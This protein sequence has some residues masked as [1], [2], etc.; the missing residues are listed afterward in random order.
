MRRVLVAVVAVLSS[1]TLV[2]PALASSV[3]GP[4][5]SDYQH[6]NGVSIGWGQ[7]ATAG[8]SFAFVK[9]SQGTYYTNPYYA[10]DVAQAGKAGLVHGAYA[11]ADPTESAVSQAQYFAQVIGSQNQPGDLPPVL[12]LE[13]TGG[14]TA[15]QL[16]SWV[17]SWL[18]T[19]QQLTQRQP[20][21]Y[22]SPY[23]WID[24]LNNTTQFANY[25]LW[26]ADYCSC[27]APMTFGGWGAAWTFWQFTDSATISGIS[28]QV[29]ES[30][31]R[32]PLST[33][34]QSF[35]EED[36]GLPTFGVTATPGDTT[37]QVSWNAY[38]NATG[39]TV[40]SSAGNSYPAGSAT[41]FQATGLT[42]GDSYGFSITAQLANGDS[43]S[44]GWSIP[45]IPVV[46]DQITLT[47]TPNTLLSEQSTTVAVNVVRTTDGSPVTGVPL[48][49]YC[50][51]VT[52]NGPIEV[53]S[54][55]TDSNGDFSFVHVVG[56][57]D[58]YQVQLQGNPAAYVEPASGWVPVTV[59]PTLSAAP[60]QS[61][62]V[63]GSNITVSGTVDPSRGGDALTVQ[64]YLSGEWHDVASTTGN[65]TGGY[66]VPVHLGVLGSFPFQVLLAANAVHA[67]GTS[68]QFTELV[69]QASTTPVKLSATLTPSTTLAGDR[70]TISGGLSPTSGGDQLTAEADLGGVWHSVAWATANS[71]GDYTT[72]IYAGLV[73]SFPVRMVVA[74][75]TQH[76]AGT[77]PTLTLKVDPPANAAVSAA[78]S[79]AQTAQGS[80][81]TVSGVVSPASA[82]APVDVQAAIGGQWHNVASA[83]T[84]SAG[85]YAAS[86][87][88]G[89]AGSFPIQVVAPATSAYS[90]GVSKTLT[91]QVLPPASVTLQITPAT[92]TQGNRVTVS[93]TVSRA[94]AGDPVVIQALLGNQWHNVASTTTN[95]AGDYA[96]SV[97]AG[98]AG[99]FLVRSVAT[100]TSAYSTG[101]SGNATLTVQHAALTSITMAL[102]P[103]TV[104]RGGRVAV[105]GSVSPTIA[106]EPISVLALIGNQWH[107]VA[108]ATTNSAGDYAASIYA[109]LAG[110][111]PVF[112]QGPGS[113]P[114]R[115]NQIVL[116]VN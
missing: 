13:Q 75:T 67:A 56:L 111:F 109:G 48:V 93:G 62:A 95:S 57:S 50:Q 113:S 80:R 49:I 63:V 92:T 86:I 29:D 88:A 100:A 41:T 105:S 65:S 73:G 69:E 26:V 108:S 79:P 72:S 37:A 77:S 33:L 32:F 96:G 71:A 90:A 42:D 101:A 3:T 84:S 28:G 89:L 94:A 7:V 87:Y 2:L 83:T 31:F 64:A 68:A 102:S 78:L 24:N 9:A 12:D 76:A 106:G 11:F 70:V 20:M 36:S 97:Y 116:T 60:S 8:Q 115:S 74:A 53:A 110:R 44:T 82:G 66:S 114:V 52:S 5:V 43:E 19:V 45:V 103:A 35:A 17:G 23:F 39:Y 81:V 30:Q 61:P 51:F 91:L 14:L 104:A 34:R 25:P 59:E 15:T 22:V 85:G 21:I 107:L 112:A 10:Q 98:L 99:S 46:P 55:T 58:A 16:I 4:D 47:T 1:L 54:G 40:T 38:P 18:S 27:S 6:P